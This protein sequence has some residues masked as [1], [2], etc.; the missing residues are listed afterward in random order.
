MIRVLFVPTLSAGVSYWRMYN[1]REA[2][3]RNKYAESQLLWWDKNLNESHPWQQEIADPMYNA[4]IATE[5]FAYVRE[6][7]VVVFGAVQTQAALETI[8]TIRD[9][10]PDKVIITECDDDLI[11]P[12]AY[13]PASGSFRPGSEVLDIALSQMRD[14]DAVIVSTPYLKEVYGEYCDNIH[15]AT[16]SIDSTHWGQA[17]RKNHGGIRIMWAGGASHDEDLRILLPVMDKV[18]KYHPEAK[19]IMVHGAPGFVLDKPNVEDVRK[20]TRIDKYPKFLA[21]MGATIGVA[22]LVDNKFNRGKSNL[23]WLEYSA[24]GIPTVASN[25]GHFAETIKTGLDGFLAEESGQF[26]DAVI[27]LI[28]SKSLRGAVSRRAAERVAA[29]FNVDRVAFDYVRF[30]ESAVER[31]PQKKAPSLSSGID[32]DEVTPLSEILPGQDI[33][34]E[35]VTTESIQ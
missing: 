2:M 13:N 10:F 17:K 22:P 23:R 24:L 32:W 8:Y 19:W 3:R 6:A 16:N 20:W 14:S 30:L 11:D 12:P 29:D 26:A 18:Y 9:L 25:V 21:S 1:F 28:E 15:V 35:V 34:V 5:L 27:K 33:P 31:G 7:D 4:R